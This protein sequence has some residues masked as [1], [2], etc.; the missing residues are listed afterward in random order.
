LV[1]TILD[2]VGMTDRCPRCQG[3]SLVPALEGEALSPEPSY[4]ETYFPRLNLGW[5]ELRSLRAGSFKYIDA[6]EPELYDLATDPG[7]LRNIA[8]WNPERVREL[9]SDLDRVE[10]ASAGA[11]ATEEI[12]DPQVRAI[13]RSLGYLTSESA[14]EATGSRPD[15]KSRLE[16]WER[17]RAGMDLTARGETDA[18]IEALETAVAKE[19]D[20]VLARTYLALAYFERQRYAEARDQCQEILARAPEDFDGTLLLGKSLLRLGRNDEALEALKRAAA[21]DAESVEPW[22]EIAQLHLASKSRSEADAALVKATAIDQNAPS[23]LLLQGKI[24]M[25]SGSAQ[26]A[27][28]LFRAAIEAA[29][30]EE[31]PRV[32]LGNL[33]LTQRRLEEAEDLYR[34]SLALRPEA[35]AL[36]LGL[37]HARALSGKLDQAIPIFEKALELSPDSTL[38]L[39]S[40]GFAY[41]EA[42]EIEK[43]EA[44]LKRSLQIQP[45]QPELNALL[46][47]R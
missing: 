25:M 2:L 28:K 26:Y 1:P 27:E 16:V 8:A 9:D 35:A 47:R 33:F 4:A 7:E 29:P 44:V 6:P 32:Q 22:V 21:I 30:A 39:N 31:D 38:V 19:P 14:A 11:V 24:A 17:V 12:L 13:L 3:R 41:L 34:E 18:A 43:G 46:G 45:S 37:G 5:S 40:L 10:K 36:H 20:L 15:P 42:G 23:V